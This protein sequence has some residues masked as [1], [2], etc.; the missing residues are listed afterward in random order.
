MYSHPHTGIAFHDLGLQPYTAVWDLQKQLL[1]H[2]CALK[3]AARQADTPPHT[4]NYLLFCH[5]PHVYTLGKS[6]KPEHLRISPEEMAAQ[7]ISYYHIERGGDITYHGPGQL[8]GYPVIDLENFM[9]DLDRYLRGIE[10][11]II[12]TLADYGLQGH[13]YPGY[14]GVWLEPDTPRARKI[15]AIGIKCSR[16]VAMHGFAFNVNTDLRYFD[17]IV[18]CGIED[19]AVASLQ[20]ELGHPVDMAEVKDRMQQHLSAV[21]GWHYLPSQP[22][23]YPL[24]A[25]VS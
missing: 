7:G 20:Q 13:R 3:L 12:L 8:V 19:K 24:Q 5:H 10:E 25:Q 15:A 6:G 23:P 22:L 4:P 21:F 2:I 17:H 1:E 11:A 18:P 9:T 16:W 14:T